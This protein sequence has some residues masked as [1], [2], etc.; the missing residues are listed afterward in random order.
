MPKKPSENY[1]EYK[2]RMIDPI[3][4][5][6]CAAK[7]LNATIWLGSGTTTSCHHPPAH[8]IPVKELKGNPS[9]IH[10]TRHKKLMR[11]LMLKGERPYECAMCKKQFAARFTL[12]V[13]MKTHS[14]EKSY[15]CN[16]CERKFTRSDNLSQH[17]RTHTG[18]KPFE[19][20]ICEK[21]FSQSGHLSRHMKSHSKEKKIRL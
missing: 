1:I 15:Q 16:I 20:Y 11:K 2:K 6:F 21:R 10:N 18:E 12:S 17:I 13:H 4:S 19:C 14:G 9:A 3:S 7:W 5:S 8:R